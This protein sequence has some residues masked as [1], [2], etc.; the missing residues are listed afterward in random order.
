M[1]KDLTWW[2]LHNGLLVGILLIYYS[3]I[4]PPVAST[5]IYVMAVEL[6]FLVSIGEKIVH[7]FIGD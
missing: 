2:V 6:F 7:H 5:S 1:K 3:I 4:H